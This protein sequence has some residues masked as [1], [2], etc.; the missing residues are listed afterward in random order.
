METAVR[1]EERKLKAM[2][3]PC[4]KFGWLYKPAC[5][6]ATGGWGPGASAIVRSI[7]HAMSLRDGVDGLELH[8]GVASR[9]SVHLMK[10]VA[11]MLM[12]G[13]D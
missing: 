6:E 13:H 5:F 7:T 9:V 4:R 10:G 11:E 2:L 3:V 12:R 1:H 8:Q